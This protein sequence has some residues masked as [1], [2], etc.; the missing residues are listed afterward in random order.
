MP[1]GLETPEPSADDL[2]AVGRDV[3]DSF[4]STG[5]AYL[6]GHGVSQQL[7]DDTFAIAKGFFDLDMDQKLAH[8]RFVRT[9]YTGYTPFG[10]DNSTNVTDLTAGITDFKECF[11]MRCTDDVSRE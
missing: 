6:S 8:E 7:Q 4:S 10:G 11:D 9:G 5:F 2:L 1:T 3:V